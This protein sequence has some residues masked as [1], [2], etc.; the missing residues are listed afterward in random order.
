MKNRTG[1]CRLA[2]GGN[3]RAVSPYTDGNP[4]ADEGRRSGDCGSGTTEGWKPD[5]A[6]GD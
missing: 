4:P 6:T 5:A 1:D 2:A 3:T